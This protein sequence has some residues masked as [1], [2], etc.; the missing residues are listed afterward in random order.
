[1]TGSPG[2]VVYPLAEVLLLLTC[3][4]VASCDDF[5][6]IVEWGEHHGFSTTVLGVSFRCPVRAL[7][8]DAGQSRRPCVVRTLFR[9]LDQSAV[10]RRHDLIDIDGKT[11]RRTHGR[12]A[13]HHHQDSGQG[14]LAH[15][16]ER[17]EVDVGALC[18]EI[19][20][21]YGGADIAAEAADTDDT[22]ELT[23]AP[24]VLDFELEDNFAYMEGGK[25][26]V[27]P[28]FHHMC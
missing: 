12:A 4:T 7:A 16:V 17:L 19:V 2:R 3:A 27:G 14:G 23:A 13:L 11:S 20:Q 8:A 21:E 24:Y 6:D 10:A 15:R 5:E 26:Y 28:A 9:K 1:M 18:D 22:I 25:R